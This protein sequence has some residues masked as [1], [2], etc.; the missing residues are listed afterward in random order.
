MKDMIKEI[1]D[2]DHEAQQI[3]DAAQ[4]KKLNSAEEV[5][6]RREEIRNQYLA[7]ARKRIE[8]NEPAEQAFAEEEWKK[9]EKHYAAVREKLEADYQKNGDQWVNELVGRVLG[10]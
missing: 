4:M 10:A 5:A 9:T 1:V 6:K 3:T 2:I 7:R 8:K